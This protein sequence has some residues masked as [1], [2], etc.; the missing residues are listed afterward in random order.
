MT[1]PTVFTRS[2]QALF[3]E[4]GDDVVALHLD[5]GQTYG[6]EKVTAAVWRLLAQPTDIDSI[7]A[8]LL[9]NYQVDPGVCRDDVGRLLDQFEREGLIRRLA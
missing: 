3:A 1:S 5:R 9:E 8:G 4:I 6:M 2:E 7:C